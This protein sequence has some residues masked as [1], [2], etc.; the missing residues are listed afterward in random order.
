MNENYYNFKL[1]QIVPEGETVLWQ[2]KPN[3][4]C[5]IFE[6]IFNPFFPIALIWFLIDATFIFFFATASTVNV[7][8][9]ETNAHDELHFIIPFFAIHLMPV[10][11]YL[12]G[13]IR[14]IRRYNNTEF[15]LT[16]KAIY[17]SGEVVRRRM[18]DQLQEIQIR[19]GYF[20]KI[21]NVG[22]IVIEEYASGY[23][24]QAGANELAITDI[25]EFMFV[26]DLII[27]KQEEIKERKRNQE[28][29]PLEKMPKEPPE[30][31]EGYRRIDLE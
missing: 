10:W 2:G 26:Y 8:G 28:N 4:R 23:R 30:N 29:K 11:I 16:D 14:S 7:N 15:I 6:C 31:A 21:L 25:S 27:Q 12:V 17:I 24:R 5:F 19:Q 20:D 18:Y 3:K 9:R 13:V 22:D 1:M